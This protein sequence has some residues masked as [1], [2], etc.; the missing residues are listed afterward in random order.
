[1]ITLDGNLATGTVGGL[2]AY[3][4]SLDQHRARLQVQGSVARNVRDL[5][6][7][8]AYARRPLQPAVVWN[9][10]DSRQVQCPVRRDASSGCPVVN[11][12]LPFGVP[13]YTIPSR[14]PKPMMTS[15]SSAPSFPH[16]GGVTLT[17]GPPSF[18]ITGP[19]PALP[20]TDS[21]TITVT[22]AGNPSYTIFSTGSELSS[23]SMAVGPTTTIAVEGA[24]TVGGGGAG[25]GPW[26][27]TQLLRL[28]TRNLSTTGDHSKPSEGISG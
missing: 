24:G 15:S 10:I 5:I 23:M 19:G 28:P 6:K 9:G 26:N 25:F 2:A 13:P 8:L 17:L 1:M 16:E 7:E 12:T 3:L 18:N 4:L 27:I 11:T 22:L 21:A 20:L 14:I